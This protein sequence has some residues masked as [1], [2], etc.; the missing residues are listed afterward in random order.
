M[1]QNLGT[2][3]KTIG[4]ESPFEKNI[5][6]K[7]EENLNEITVYTTSEEDDME[8]NKSI[9]TGAGDIMTEEWSI[10][11]NMSD[12]DR[13]EKEEGIKP[14]LKERSHS[15][16]WWMEQSSDLLIQKIFSSNKQKDLIDGI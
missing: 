8:I 9:S 15:L 16:K 14:L 11:N 2:I 6:K 10:E 7:K 1:I 3:E 5:R 12:T 4:E 13:K